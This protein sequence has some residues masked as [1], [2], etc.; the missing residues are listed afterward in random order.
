MNQRT[1]INRPEPHRA[2]SP[3]GAPPNAEITCEPSLALSLGNDPRIVIPMIQRT[4]MCFGDL[5]N[6]FEIF[7]AFAVLGAATEVDDPLG[8]IVRAVRFGQHILQRDQLVA[9]VFE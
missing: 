4:F 6:D 7:V 9:P 3:P 5:L 8:H 1:F 2:A